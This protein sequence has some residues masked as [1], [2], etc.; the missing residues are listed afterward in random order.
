MDVEHQKKFR[1]IWD[2]GNYRLG[3]T[4]QRMASFIAARIP[5]GSSI[6]DYGSGTGRAEVALLKSNPYKIT[7]IDIAENALEDEARSI[8]GSPD[9]PLNMIIADLADLSQVPLAEWGMCINVL[10][11]VQPEKLDRILSEISRTCRNL[12]FEAYDFTDIR[13]GKDMTTVKKNRQEWEEKLS[14]YWQDVVFEPSPESVRRYI[15]VC[16]GSKTFDR[17]RVDDGEKSLPADDCQIQ[18]LQNKYSGQTCYIVGRGASLLDLRKGHFGA[19]PVIVINEAIIN[20]ANLN[21]DNDIYSQWRNGDIPL[22]IREYL[23]PD[24]ALLLCDN[25]VPVYVSTADQFLDYRPLYRFECLRDFGADPATMFSHLAALEIAVRI[26]GCTSIVNMGFDSYRADD[27]TVLK[28]GFVQSE[29]RAG[30]YREQVA[31]FLKRLAQMPLIEAEWFFPDRQPKPLKLNIGCG[32]VPVDGYVNIDLNVAAD[33]RMDALHLRYPENSV[34]EIYSS[35][36]LEHFSKRD[37]PRALNEWR[38]VLVPGGKLIMNL[39]NIEWCVKNWLSKSESERY[40]LYLDMIYGLQTNDGEYHKTGFTKPRLEQLLREAGFVDITIEDH[41]SH[42]Q[43]CF[44]VEAAKEIKVTVV[45]LTGDR[46]AAFALCRRWMEKQTRQPD[47]WLIVDDGKE[48]LSPDINALAGC[49][50]IRREPLPDDPRHTMIINM[51]EAVKHIKGDLIIIMEDDEYYAP[52]YIETLVEKLA[53]YEVVGIGRSKYYHMSSGAWMQDCN[54]DN[55]SL[56]Q[57]AFRASFMPEFCALLDGNQYVDMR[58]WKHV[59]RTDVLRWNKQCK[60]SEQIIQDR[61][62][63]FDDGSQ[64]LYVGMKGL[65][66][67]FGICWGHSGSHPHYTEKDTADRDVLKRWLG[68]DYQY[69]DQVLSGAVSAVKK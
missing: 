68:E 40:G 64:N 60:I 26:F 13:L 50:Y 41:W 47:Q 29:Y 28:N 33:V 9:S 7:M 24:D 5:A 14:E 53:Q 45:T 6:T 61:G 35:H 57:T 36:L 18:Q 52:R 12:I 55:A 59:G 31:R 69:Y 44:K 66:G 67:R 48:P 58:I 21:L 4:A 54:M 17:S 2:E 62:Y 11:V 27:R 56:A 51:K 65:P 34:D 37:V 42:A 30:D 49:D 3:S 25:P 1:K 38:R 23:K 63:I 10:M 32:D 22:D 20:I 46:P 39:P 8:L 16:K 43:G 15:F 19:G